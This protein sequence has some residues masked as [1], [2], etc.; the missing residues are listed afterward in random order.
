MQAWTYG[1][2]YSI[3]IYLNT[4]ELLSSQKHGKYMVVSLLILI[5]M[6]TYKNEVKMICEL[7]RAVLIYHFERNTK[8]V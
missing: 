5:E 3:G 2:G 6:L 7:L 4:F 8:P 1:I